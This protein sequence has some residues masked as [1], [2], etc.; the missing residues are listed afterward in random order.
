ME[1]RDLARG[2]HP[3]VLDHGLGT[4]LTTLGAR[5]G[6]PV[7]VIADLPER[8]SAA[9]E[10]IAY[11]CAAELLA[12]VAK[13][14]R[15][16]HATIEAVHVPGLLR[17]RVSDDGDGGARA[18]DGGGLAGLAE[19]LRTVDGTIHDQ[20]PAWRPY[21]GHRRDAVP[22]LKK[23]GTQADASRHR[24][25]LSRGPGRP[26]RDPGRP[27]AR[28]GRRRRRRRGAA[29]R[30]GRAPPGRHRGGRA[31][32]ARLHRR[33]AAGRDRDPAGPPGDR[34]AGVLAVRRDPLRGRPAAVRPRR[35]APPRGRRRVP[36][37]GPGGRRRGVHRGA[38]PGGGRRH[39]ARPRGGQ[40]AAGRQR[41]RPT[42][43]AASPTASATCS[44]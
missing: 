6:L 44:R 32:A 14:S 30:R 20:Q 16:R 41:A 35:V 38:R 10:T 23:A 19:R 36:P 9:I 13:H 27:R 21:G 31:D 18:R 42:C 24:G 22:R 37:Q 12:N 7:E 29:G 11:F 4:A 17:V 3:P 26:G 8:P 28:G 2:I 43:S 33:G 34:G 15:A 1:L 25:G 40:P 5:S 39:R